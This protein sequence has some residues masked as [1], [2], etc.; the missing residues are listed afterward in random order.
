MLK[1]R[2]FYKEGALTSHGTSLLKKCRGRQSNLGLPIILDC[3]KARINYWYRLENIPNGLLKDA[4]LESKNIH[5]EG[6]KSWFSAI[7]N[8][9]TILKTPGGNKYKKYSKSSFKHSI[10]TDLQNIYIK[11]WYDNRNQLIVENGT[12]RTYLK[13]KT[14]FGFEK[15]L[16]LITDSEL[17]R[18]ITKFKISCHKLKIEVGRHTKPK[19]PLED[20]ICDRCND[21]CIDDE[22]HFFNHCTKLSESRNILFNIIKGTNMNFC[23]LSSFNKLYWTLNCENLNI[24]NNFGKFLL[25]SRLI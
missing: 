13:I 4:Y 21:L 8:L 19:T 12:L 25:E 16:E 18:S 24:L 20:R 15:Y 7:T 23:S 22:L 14:N 11:T 6:G 5:E 2:V 17:R 1:S 10:K 3:F 9:F